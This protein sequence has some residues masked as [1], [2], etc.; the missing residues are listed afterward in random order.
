MEGKVEGQHLTDDHSGLV[1]NT[2]DEFIVY[3]QVR[4]AE[5]PA[6]TAGKG[7]AAGAD[8]SLY[9][10]PPGDTA[11]T[12]ASDAVTKWH[13]LEDAAAHVDAA[14]VADQSLTH[15]TQTHTADGWL[16]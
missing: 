13:A 7:D 12:T 8:D 1:V 9:F 16:L 2:G 10:H 5:V 11:G 14:T 6:D 3:N 15:D 4:G